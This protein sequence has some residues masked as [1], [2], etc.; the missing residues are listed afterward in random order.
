M[1]D[2]QRAFIEFALQNQVLRFGEF[3]LKSG[4]RSP[5]FFN[6]GLFNSGA[7]LSR[8]GDFYAQA[9]VAS[10]IKYDMLFG[11][12]YKGI[13]LASAAA[14]S[15]ALR[16]DKD[17]PFGF[18]R[19]EAKAHGEGGRTLGA[20]LAGQVLIIDDVISAG[21]SVNAA[22]ALIRA[23]HAIPVGVM[24]ALDRQE[25][26]YSPTAVEDRGE[27]SAI[28]EVEQNH[29]LRVMSLITLDHL[30]EYLQGLPAMAKDLERIKTYRALYGVKG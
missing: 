7:R 15:L 27:R 25:R 23:A 16:Y 9:I 20:L 13:P 14:I 11:P 28:E 18:D 2:F 4:R 8:L 5:Y 19:K 12:A 6:S 22:I 29:G 21:T 3:T 17:V 24:I 1:Q 30:I 26:G 10:G